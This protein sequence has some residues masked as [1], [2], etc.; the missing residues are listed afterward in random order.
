MFKSKGEKPYWRILFEY[1]EEKEIGDIV[2]YKDL[3]NQ[4][5]A[6]IESQRGSI[7]RAGKELLDI[8]GRYIESVRGEGYK[9]ISGKD[10]M[11]FSKGRTRKMKRQASLQEFEFN[12]I[13]TVEL[14]ADDRKK[15]QDLMVLNANIR[16]ALKTSVKNIETGVNMTRNQLTAANA[17]LAGAQIAQLFTE[18]QL[19]KLK[20]MVGE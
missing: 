16:T 19:Q 10:I 4:I 9:I 17:N 14:S 13:N 7:Y 18:H 12:G 2:S 5:K 8:H 6:D 11:V 1:L 3:T 20:E 15:L